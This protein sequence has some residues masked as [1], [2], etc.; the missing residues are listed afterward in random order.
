MATCPECD[1]DLDVDEYDV[2][3]GD[4]VSCQDCGKNFEVTGTTPLELEELEED[5]DEEDED[6]DDEDDDEDDE[7]DD[8]EEEEEEDWDE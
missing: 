3:K 4:I 2:D 8:E 5:D 1:A 6:E 7:D